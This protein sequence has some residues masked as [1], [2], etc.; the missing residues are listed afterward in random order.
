MKS[1]ISLNITL[2]L[3]VDGKA[4]AA[5]LLT[6]SSKKP[7]VKKTA[8]FL[9]EG[10]SDE[11]SS[12]FL[13]EQLKEFL[14][15][16]SSELSGVYLSLSHQEVLFKEITLPAATLANLA[17]VIAYE[18]ENYFPF[19]GIDLCYDYRVLGPEEDNGFIRVLLTC[20]KRKVYSRYLEI[21]ARLGLT[22]TSI[23]PAETSLT[24]LFSS[25]AGDPELAPLMVALHVGTGIDLVLLNGRGFIASQYLHQDQDF[26]GPKEAVHAASSLFSTYVKQPLS[27]EDQYPNLTFIGSN[28]DIDHFVRDFQAEASLYFNLKDPAAEM[29]PTCTL[30]NIPPRE[31]GLLWL[32]VGAALEGKQKTAAGFNFIPVADRPKEKKWLLK[33]T[34]V[35][36]AIL[37]LALGAYLISPV[38]IDRGKFKELTAKKDKLKPQVEQIE[39]KSSEIRK[40]K[41]SAKALKKFPDTHALIVLSEL[42]TLVP[43][44]TWLRLIEL[45]GDTISVEGQSAAASA[46]LP[47]LEKSVLFQNAN[48]ASPVNKTPQGT[49]MFRMTMERK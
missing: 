13:S 45:K 2:G 10:K 14:G 30:E 38:I 5:V 1:L 4:L 12:I 19:D 32:A 39:K 28:A 9:I 47:I 23:F 43:D 36:L 20:I 35:N 15:G 27:E 31:R 16:F 21:L 46:L 22:L 48:F 37:L 29:P 8:V 11:E 7:G 33:F 44:N 49:E 24:N 42:T 40:L 26:S 34:Y 3:A 6:G 18:V 25:W 17:Q 41:E